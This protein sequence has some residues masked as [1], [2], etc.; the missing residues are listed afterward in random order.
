MTDQEKQKLINEFKQTGR[1]KTKGCIIRSR[2][3]WY[4]EG[5]IN[6][7]YFLNLEKRHCKSNTIG[8]LKTENETSITPDKDILK[9]CKMFYTNLF[10]AKP[11]DINDDDNNYFRHQKTSAN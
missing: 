9:E 4:N 3:R 6:S 2:A 10:R 8:H 11:K 5:E 7:K 1:Y